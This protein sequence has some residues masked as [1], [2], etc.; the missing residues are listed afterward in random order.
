MPRTIQSLSADQVAAFYRR[1]FGEENIKRYVFGINEYAESVAAIASIDGYID[2]FSTDTTWLGKPVY[3]LGDITTDSMVISCVT[4]SFPISALAHLQQ[5]GIR[6]YADYLSLADMSGGRLAQVS[7][8]TETRDDYRDNAAN[9]RW[10]REH[11]CDELSQDIFDRLMNFRLNGDLQPMTVF[12]YAADRQYFEPFLELQAGEVFVDGGGFDGA[13]SREFASR[14]PDYKAIHVFEPSAKM[15]AVAQTKLSDLD[16]ITF[17]PLGLFDKSAN[18]SFD[19]G[20]GSASR[21]SE[22][23]SESI[24]VNRMDDAVSETVSFIKLDLEGAEQAALK[25]AQDH[26]M[27]DHPKL[28]VAV[29]HRPE[30]FWKIPKYILGLREDYKL[31]LRHYTEGWT[32]TVMFFIPA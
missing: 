14:C 11:L 10:V 25:G 24:K 30:D 17:H 23:G 16:R 7:A 5:A 19:A 6:H 31:Y 32:E 20:G 4:A 2:D 12:G 1:F 8:I 26:I 15:L 28:A 29:Y 18:L 3:K 21:I 13:T 9:Y 22:S 27:T